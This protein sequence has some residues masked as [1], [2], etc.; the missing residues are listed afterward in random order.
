MSAKCSI[1]ESTTAQSCND[2][3]CGYLE[4]GNGEPKYILYG[5]A[6]PSGKIYA[7]AMDAVGNCEQSFVKLYVNKEDMK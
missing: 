7:S 5:Y 2:I 1:C 4:S 6:T 3:G